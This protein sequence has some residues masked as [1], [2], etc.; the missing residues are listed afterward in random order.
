MRQAQPMLMQEAAPQHLRKPPI[1]RSPARS[2]PS[3]A[4]DRNVARATLLTGSCYG[5]ENVGQ[6]GCRPFATHH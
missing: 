4:S 6:S 1:L 5:I 3:P 2:N